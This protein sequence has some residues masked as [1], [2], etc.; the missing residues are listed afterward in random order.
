VF[1]RVAFCGICTLEQRLYTGDM[2][3][4]Y[5]LIPGHE[6]SGTVAAIGSEVL[7]DLKVGDR[8]AVDL[9]YRCH[10]CYYCR[11]GLTNLCENRFSSRLSLLGGLG[12][13]IAVQASQVFRIGESLAL[14]QAAFAEPTA[15]CLR[16]LKKINITAAEQVLISGAGPMGLLHLQAARAMGARVYVTDV[17][18]R[19]L[20]TARELGA[21]AVF[22][23]AREE[24][25]AEIK[26]R[27]G[28]RGA[29]ACVITTPAEAAL[30]QAFSALRKGGRVNVYTAYMG[31]KICLPVDMQTLHRNEYLVTGTEGRTEADFL[32]AVGLLCSGQIRTEPL[33]S[34]V[35]PLEQTEAAVAAAM[36]VETQRVLVRVG[37]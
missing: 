9:V 22:N 8:C 14:E 10:E 6:V 2:T 7:T 20:E 16:S 15:C 29:D 13:Y 12:E 21:E 4:R 18:D 24:S 37:S 26:A 33:T 19:R 34:A 11:I 36:S 27:T 28:G 31:E 35:Y 5:P 3:I 23:P 25:A 30:K 17:E 1:I 32:Q